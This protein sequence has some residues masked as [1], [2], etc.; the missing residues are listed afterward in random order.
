M[1]F[2]WTISSETASQTLEKTFWSL[3]HFLYSLLSLL[4][5]RNGSVKLSSKHPLSRN[6]GGER[7]GRMKERLVTDKVVQHTRTHFKNHSQL[8]HF[9]K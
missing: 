7:A 9:K 6:I 4:A 1:I 8:M 5:V 3:P 2:M